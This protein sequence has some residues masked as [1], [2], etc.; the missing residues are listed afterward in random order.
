MITINQLFK[1]ILTLKEIKNKMR[2]IILVLILFAIG[3]AMLINMLIIRPRSINFIRGQINEGF[4]GYI[5]YKNNQKGF[6][7]YLV[8]DYQM[9]ERLKLDTLFESEAF[10]K[11]KIGGF[12]RHIIF[13]DSL[14]YRASQIGDKI[15]K[16]PNSN[17]CVLFVKEAVFKFNCYAISSDDRKQAA[18]I[19]EWKT[20]EIGYWKSIYQ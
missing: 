3:S 10:D 1:P 11:P 20:N 14:L 15:E 7:L 12:I 16:L 8:D 2:K 4:N 13:A 19:K 6:Y 5:A 9:V 18:E 17:K